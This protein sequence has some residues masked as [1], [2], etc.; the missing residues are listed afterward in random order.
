ADEIGADDRPLERQRQRERKAREPV[1]RRR[2]RSDDQEALEFAGGG[3]MD[4]RVGHGAH[5]NS[6]AATV[7][8]AATPSARL[9][10]STTANSTGS[11]WS[12]PRPQSS[13]TRL[14]K[15]N[16]ITGSAHSTSGIEKNAASTAPSAR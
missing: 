7:S 3:M 14:M 8:I 11:S 10:R 4:G 1:D 5:P 2:Q 16:R 9:W 13:Q 12:S 6:A 15:R